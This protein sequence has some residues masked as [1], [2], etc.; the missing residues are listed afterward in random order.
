MTEPISK[1]DDLYQRF[2]FHPAT[3]LTGPMHEEVRTRCYALA[4]S[5]A[6]S[7]PKCRE[8]SLALTHL[9]NTMMW[10]N[11]AIAIHGDDEP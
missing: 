4:R 7:L 1:S 5:L 2:S 3:D 9:Q 10:A 6:D 8:T 11:A